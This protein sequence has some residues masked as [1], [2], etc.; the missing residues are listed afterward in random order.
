M[1]LVASQNLVENIQLAQISTQQNLNHLFIIKSTWATNG[2]DLQ[3]SPTT[4]TY[5]DPRTT[6][7]NSLKNIPILGIK[8]TLLAWLLVSEDPFH[9]RRS[10]LVESRTIFYSL[11]YMQ[12]TSSSG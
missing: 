10:D 3:P 4:T 11:E 5:L 6:A 8:T 2:C 7:H 1:R 9:Y 12:K